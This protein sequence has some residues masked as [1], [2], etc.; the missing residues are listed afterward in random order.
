[1][2]RLVLD[3]NVLGRI[4]HPTPSANHAIALW[5]LDCLNSPDHRLVI[6]E[7]A[8]FECRRLLIWR[9]IHKG[10]P[11]AKGSLQRL[12]ALREAADFLPIDSSVML[13]AADLWAQAR[14]NGRTTDADKAVG[15]DVIL[16]AQALRCDG[17][18]VVTENRRH[19]AQYVTVFP[20]EKHLSSE[21]W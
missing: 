17:A 14:A 20:L 9:A 19:L 5:A 11:E 6:P 8:D 18:Q 10:V 4:C 12:N 16:A 21:I 13:L 3:S 7:I 15:A 1:M 2:L